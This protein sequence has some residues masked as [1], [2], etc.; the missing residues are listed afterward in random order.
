MAAAVVYGIVHDQITARICVEYFTIGHPP[1]FDTDDPTRLGIGW[2]IAATWWVGL[3][4]GLVLAV[5]ARAGSRPKRSALDLIRPITW[6]LVIMGGC[7]A[8]AGGVGWWLADHGVVVLRGNLADRIPG[9]RQVRFLADAWAHS[10]SYLVGFV[11]GMALAV[12]VWLSRRNAP[13]A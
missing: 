11:G 2:G 6:L 3:L 12:R 10:T 7:A 8:V 5:A 4:L 9:D 1:L 13:A